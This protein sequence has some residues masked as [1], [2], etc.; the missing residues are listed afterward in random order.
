MAYDV[1]RFTLNK[2]PFRPNPT[3]DKAHHHNPGVDPLTALRHATSGL[4]YH[5]L[6]E[7]DSPKSG[8]SIPQL[9][10]FYPMLGTAPKR[11]L[12]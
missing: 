6:N 10:P 7:R 12:R 5:K 2:Q 8:D 9:L 1:L 3:N 11:P 4:P